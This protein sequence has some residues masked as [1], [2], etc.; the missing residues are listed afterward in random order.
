M[1]NTNHI[2]IGLFIMVS[3]LFAGDLLPVGAD[4]PDFA[5]PDA[6]GQ[7]HKLSDYLGKKV[8]IYFYPKDGTPGCTKEACNLRDNYQAL[9]DRGLV[10]LGISYDDAE[11]HKEFIKEHNLPFTLLSDTDKKVAD[12]YGAKGGLLGFIGAKR[13]TYLIDE[14][15]KIMHVFD[16]VD[17]GDHADQIL[18]VLNEE[19]T[20]DTSGVE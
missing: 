8:V 12:M 16:D 6:Q 20:A 14:H 19:S 2:L 5:L 18:A 11:S 15:G 1:S 17:T 10:I 7:V 9:Q 13:I 3:L 4:A